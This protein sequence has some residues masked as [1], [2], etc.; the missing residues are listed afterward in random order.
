[1]AT[2]KTYRRRW[3]RTTNTNTININDGNNNNN[4]NNN[5]NTF[6]SSYHIKTEGACNGNS[7]GDSKKL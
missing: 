6:N 1:M 4:N 5:N 3:N 2:A 7:D